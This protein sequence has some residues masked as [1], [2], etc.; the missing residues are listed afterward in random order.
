MKTKICAMCVLISFVLG[1]KKETEQVDRYKIFSDSWEELSIHTNKAA[2][3]IE[4][5]TENPKRL[6]KLDSATGRVWF[7]QHE[8]DDSGNKEPS[9]WIEMT[10]SGYVFPPSFQTENEKH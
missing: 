6:I 4:I 8:T 10:D 9:G 5:F 7:W 1:C 3:K 2:G